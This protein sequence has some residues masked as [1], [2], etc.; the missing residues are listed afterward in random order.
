MRMQGKVAVVTGAASGNGRAI[1][2]RLAAEGAHVVCGD[3]NAAGLAAVVAGIA[4]AGGKAEAVHCDVTS[5]GD[6]EQ[7]VSAAASLG[8]PHA[9]VAQAGASYENKL[10]DTT[11]EAWDRFMAVD[12]TG[13]YLCMRAAIPRM[14]ALGGGSIVAMSGTYAIKAEPG[15]AVQ[16]AAKGAIMSLVRG[17]AV[18]VGQ[19]GIRVNCIAPGYIETPMVQRWAQAQPDPGAVRAAAASMHALKRMGT[20][21]EVAGM[22][23][24]L[25]SD[26]SSFCTGHAYFVDGGLAI[27]ENGGQHQPAPILG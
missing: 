26:E 8:G 15:V 9:M 24:F 7:L 18:E 2:E 5:P 21:G 25:C 20:A 19:D 12:V 17:V 3:I 14:R 10:E 23:L 11:P 4:A 22:A 27:S 1:A 16:C 13:T 6:V